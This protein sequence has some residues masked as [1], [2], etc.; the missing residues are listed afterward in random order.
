MRRPIALCV[1]VLAA[2]HGACSDES[3]QDAP[4]G[5]T[6]LLRWSELDLPAGRSSNELEVVAWRAIPGSLPEPLAGADEPLTFVPKTAIRGS[7]DNFGRGEAERRRRH[8]N[9]ATLPDDV[10]LACGG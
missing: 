2:A 4:R 10:P 8:R 3:E 1:A 5:A 9:E 7:G 6:L